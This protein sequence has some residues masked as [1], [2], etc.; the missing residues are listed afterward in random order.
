[1]LLLIIELAKINI[2]Y[3]ENFLD[4]QYKYNYNVFKSRLREMNDMDNLFDDTELSFAMFRDV[5]KMFPEK[6]YQNEK[7]IEALQQE[8]QDLLHILEF[9]NFSAYQGYE[10]SR[11]I[12]ELR[13][14]RRKLK[15]ENELLRPIIPLLKKYRN[16]LQ[17]METLLKEIK[18]IK[19]T[20][21]SRNYRCRVRKDLQPSFHQNKI[22]GL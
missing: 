8:Q 13:Q 9:S 17:N 4:Y 6:Y 16:D 10:L 22:V 14:K 11:Q 1:M 3:L 15:N 18:R 20:Q 2:N 21:S 5:V 19:E 7:E 12:K